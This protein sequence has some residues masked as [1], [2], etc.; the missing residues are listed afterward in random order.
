[1]SLYIR[2]QARAKVRRRIRKKISGTAERPRAKVSKPFKKK[3]KEYWSICMP[4]LNPT[5]QSP[6]MIE[7]TE[8]VLKSYVHWA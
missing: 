5:T 4:P 8:Q 6:W 3:E 1:M 7:I 2:K